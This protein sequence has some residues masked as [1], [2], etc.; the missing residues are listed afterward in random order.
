MGKPQIAPTT[1]WL[2]TSCVVLSCRDV[3]RGAGPLDHG[4]L[5]RGGE[6][7]TA[8]AGRLDETVAVFL[9]AGERCKG[10]RGKCLAGR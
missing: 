3:K 5:L 9:S 8:D 2:P 6:P 4:S 7:Q 10:F 1:M